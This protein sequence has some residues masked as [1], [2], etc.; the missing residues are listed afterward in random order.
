MLALAFYRMGLQPRFA[1]HTACHWY[2]R[3]FVTGTI[4]TL[5]PFSALFLDDL[6]SVLRLPL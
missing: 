3:R 6:R 1:L 5:R 4:L 2:N